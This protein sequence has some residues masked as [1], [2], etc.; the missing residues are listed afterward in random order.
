[1]SRKPGDGFPDTKMDPETVNRIVNLIKAGNFAVVAAKSAGI[2]QRTYTSWMNKG[3]Y[4]AGRRARGEPPVA[5]KDPYVHFYYEVESAIA[6]AEGRHVANLMK[7]SQDDWRASAFYLERKHPERWAAKVNIE[8]KKEV[9]HVLRKLELLL[10][11]EVYDLVLEAIAT[12][13]EM[14]PG[15]LTEDDE[16][17]DG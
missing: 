8:I 15:L 16:D 11:E 6:E 10:E 3:R 2:A 9:D 14:V 4:E 1:M 13:D 17:D 5:S 12:P 7:H